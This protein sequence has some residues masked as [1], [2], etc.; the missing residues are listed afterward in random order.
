MQE[1]EPHRPAGIGQPRQEEA[2]HDDVGDDA[3]DAAPRVCL[4][5]QPLRYSPRGVS[6]RVDGQPPLAPSPFS[7]LHDGAPPE[8]LLQN[9][10]V[11]PQERAEVGDGLRIAPA[12]PLPLLHL[13]RLRPS[14]P[15]RCCYSCDATFMISFAG[16]LGLALSRLTTQRSV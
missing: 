13:R 14:P 10:W 3:Q 9:C 2:E 1:E 11:H 7:H 16:D 12:G 8:L 6:V 4:D 5:P 15:Q